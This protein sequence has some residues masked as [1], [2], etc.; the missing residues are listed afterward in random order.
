MKLKKQNVIYRTEDPEQIQV[1]KSQ[2]FKEVKPKSK[3][4]LSP[5][6]GSNKPNNN[7]DGKDKE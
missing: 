7:K 4:D 2:G 5:K 3:L 1:L 6:E